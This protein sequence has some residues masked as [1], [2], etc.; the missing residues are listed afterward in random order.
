[1][2]RASARTRVKNSSHETRSASTPAKRQDDSLVLTPANDLAL[3]PGA[4]RKADALAKFVEGERWEELGEMEKAIDSY[5]KVLTVDP[6]Q[7]DLATHVATLLTQQEDIPLAID[8][9]KDAI[10]A[11]P[12]E[13]APYLQLAV[14]YAKDLKKM[15][16]ALKYAEQAVA[17]DPQNIEAYQ[18]VYEIDLAM[19]QPQKAL[20]SL[21]R[22]LQ[23]QTKDADF[24]LQ[25]GKLFA[26]VLFKADTEPT[27]EELQR[28]NS[29][30]TKAAELGAD[31][32][33]V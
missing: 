28:V 21:D 13:A 12:K 18:R 11:N 2:E 8:I 1:M 31:D 30:F 19:G 24:W 25:L 20:A 27:P 10:K 33:H 22:A 16:Q 29:I 7:I 14:L 5:Q 26:S 6:G 9:L 3:Q 4:A 15:E 23:V 32:P 17:L